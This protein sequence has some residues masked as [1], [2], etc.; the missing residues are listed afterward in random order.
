VLLRKESQLLRADASAFRVLRGTASRISSSPGRAAEATWL[1]ESELIAGT[2][3]AAGRVAAGVAGGAAGGAIGA[4][5][6]GAVLETAMRDKFD[7]MAAPHARIARRSAC[8]SAEA[9]AARLSSFGG[10][11]ARSGLGTAAARAA[12]E[13]A[14]G[15]VTADAA[16]EA[17][18]CVWSDACL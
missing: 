1:R 17:A 12:V 2:T 4:A 18:A 14:V 7:A 3:G 16:A 8:G 11:A 10:A 9:G 6:A 13:A 15:A 5:D